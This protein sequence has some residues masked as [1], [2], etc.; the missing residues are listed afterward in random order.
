MYAISR[1]IMYTITS[2]GLIHVTKYLGNY[3]VL[4]VMIPVMIGY[5]WGI[6]YFEKLEK[7]AGRY[8]TRKKWFL[9]MN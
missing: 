9:A 6:F 3:G 8:P 1:T 4:I 7:A 5:S 2:F